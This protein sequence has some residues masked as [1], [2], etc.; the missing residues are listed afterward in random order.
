M[1]LELI[2]DREVAEF[3]RV[4]FP[5]YGVTARPVAARRG[6]DIDR[7]ANAV[8]G[9]VAR[10]AHLREIPAGP[11]IARAPFRIGLE[12]TAG[13]HHRFR[14][15]FAHLA[16]LAHADALDPVAVEQQIEAARRIVDVDA[17]LFCRRG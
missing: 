17:A 16:V 13:E 15:Q 5:L 7:H 3:R 11:E 2:A 4:H 12:T 14:P 9:V 1:F 6:P 10:T 8:A